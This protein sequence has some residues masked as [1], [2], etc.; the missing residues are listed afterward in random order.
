[1]DKTMFPT[2]TAL[3]WYGTR[4]LDGTSMLVYW[5]RAALLCV[6]GG[7][8]ADPDP[9]LAFPPLSMHVRAA[10]NHNC[11]RLA[12]TVRKFCSFFIIP[13]LSGLFH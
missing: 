4:V 12:N 9:L 1:M 6:C 13:F 7:R 3:P 8:C 11:A 10:A 5:Y 2:K